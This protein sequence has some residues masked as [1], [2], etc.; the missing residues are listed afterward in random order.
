[1]VNLYSLCMSN[2]KIEYIF[3]KQKNK[4]LSIVIIIQINIS[5]VNNQNVDFACI[6]EQRNPVAYRGNN[7]PYV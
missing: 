6:P 4:P 5:N 2:F 3:A 7:R 1:M